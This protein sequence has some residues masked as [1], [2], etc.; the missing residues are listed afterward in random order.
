M[1][2]RKDRDRK[3]GRESKGER[4]IK[5]ERYGGRQI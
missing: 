4:E 1:R 5:H 2:E 3:R